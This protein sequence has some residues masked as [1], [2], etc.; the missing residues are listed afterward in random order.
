[1]YMACHSAK[2]TH[3]A[4]AERVAS[5]LVEILPQSLRTHS[6]VLETLDK[7]IGYAFFQIA[8]W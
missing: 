1:M 2:A 4:S 7:S 6:R 5:I 8:E 3:S